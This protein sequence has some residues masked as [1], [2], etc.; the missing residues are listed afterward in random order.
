VQIDNYRRDSG[1]TAIMSDTKNI[2]EIEWTEVHAPRWKL[3]YDLQT[4]NVYNDTWN[5]D[6]SGEFIQ[7]TSGYEV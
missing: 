3:T 7:L 1:T 6:F 5:L 4:E 2:I